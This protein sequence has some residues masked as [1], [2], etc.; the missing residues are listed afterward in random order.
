MI[1]TVLIMITECMLLIVYMMKRKDIKESPETES[2]HKTSKE[3]AF[4]FGF[5][6]ER[7]TGKSIPEECFGCMRA[8]SCMKAT[9]H[10]SEDSK[11]KQAPI[12]HERA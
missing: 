3:C 7:P 4:Y 8:M 2:L 10:P 6:S 12:P 11:E 5:L 9:N 1:V